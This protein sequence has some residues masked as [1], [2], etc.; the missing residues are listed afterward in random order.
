MEMVD[1]MV[2]AGNKDLQEVSGIHHVQ[3]THLDYKVLKKKV[4]NLSSSFQSSVE[5]IWNRHG[6][7]G[8]IFMKES[9]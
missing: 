4:F 2:M 6:Y 7:K 5:T 3:D 9:L 8:K 1:G